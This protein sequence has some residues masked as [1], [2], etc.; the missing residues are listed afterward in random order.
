MNYTHLHVQQPYIHVYMYYIQLCTQV[1]RAM[2]RHPILITSRHTLHKE[3]DS[4][5]LDQVLSKVRVD[6]VVPWLGGLAHNATV[7]STRNTMK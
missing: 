3:S 5:F 1:V 4:Q 6:L 7:M 2:Y